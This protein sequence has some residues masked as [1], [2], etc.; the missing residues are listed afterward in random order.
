MYNLSTK[1][2]QERAERMRKL[3]SDPE[4]KARMRKLNSD[5]EFK[6]AQSERMRKLHSDPEFNPL[7][8]LTTK[9]REEYDLLRRKGGYSRQEALE[10]VGARPTI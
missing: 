5:P 10:L 9:K 1:E 2:R 3:H 6:A 4:F 8:S 7:A